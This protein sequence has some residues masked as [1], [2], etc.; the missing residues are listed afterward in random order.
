M[1]L[2]DL[3]MPKMNGIE[4]LKKIRSRAETRSLPIVILT[5]GAINLAAVVLT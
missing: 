1:Q 4:W 5:A 2:L 3:D